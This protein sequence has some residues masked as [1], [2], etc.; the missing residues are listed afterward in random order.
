MTSARTSI[1]GG[2]LHDARVK[3]GYSQKEVSKLFGYKSAQVVSDWERGLRSPPGDML[4]KMV[5]LYGVPMETF[6]E[7]IMQERTAILERKLRKS[8]GLKKARY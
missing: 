5:V 8:L 2:F 3:A 7:L 6:F 4:K 1:L